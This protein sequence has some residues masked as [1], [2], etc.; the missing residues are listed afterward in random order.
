MRKNGE[1]TKSSVK[2]KKNRKLRLR[3]WK[4]YWLVGILFVWIGNWKI[5]FTNIVS[6]C[7]S[8]SVYL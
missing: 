2:E 3:C 5:V 1:K 6:I 7:K 4:D 8:M